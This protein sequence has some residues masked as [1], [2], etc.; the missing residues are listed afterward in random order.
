V[1]G[2]EAGVGARS[3]VGTSSLPSGMAVEV[4]CV[5]EVE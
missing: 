4:E 2:D 3:A 5:F 1:F